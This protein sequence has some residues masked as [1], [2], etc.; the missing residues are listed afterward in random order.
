M[1]A[2]IRTTLYI[3]VADWT[4]RS[5]P[6]SHHFVVTIPPSISQRATPNFS[7]ST[8]CI[9]ARLACLFIAHSLALIFNARNLATNAHN[10]WVQ[11]SEFRVQSILLST[12]TQESNTVS[13]LPS[14]HHRFLHRF[15][16]HFLRHHFIHPR[17]SFRS[18]SPLSFFLQRFIH[19][20]TK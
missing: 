8:T 5:W 10:T 1:S 7:S 12:C 18:W 13:A 15:L 3:S 16:R 4:V 2:Y 6:P 11:S 9:P 19:S 20:A 14:F 17:T